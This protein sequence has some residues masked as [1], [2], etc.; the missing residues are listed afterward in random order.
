MRRCARGGVCRRRV[1]GVPFTSLD[2]PA[3]LLLPSRS[4]SA[5]ANTSV[6]PLL[7]ARAALSWAVLDRLEGVDHGVNAAYYQVAGDYCKAPYCGHSLLFLAWERLDSARHGLFR[8]SERPRTSSLRGYWSSCRP[9]AC[10]GEYAPV[11][12]HV[13]SSLLPLGRPLR[14]LEVYL[15][16]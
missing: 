8:S 10:V 2:S 16:D 5:S 13:I 14:H 15:R 11:P 12:I 7:P 6:G 1:R 9:A 4:T 3:R